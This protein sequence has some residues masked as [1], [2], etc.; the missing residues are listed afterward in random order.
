[1]T[2]LKVLIW[3]SLGG[4]AYMPTVFVVGKVG[5]TQINSKKRT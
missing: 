4:G 2:S 5:P 3:H 1:M